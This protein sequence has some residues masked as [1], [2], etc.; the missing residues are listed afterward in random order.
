[1]L[2]HYRKNNQHFCYDSKNPPTTSGLTTEP[3]PHGP[4]ADKENG[5]EELKAT[6]QMAW[7]QQMNNIRNRA[8]EIVNAEL[9]YTI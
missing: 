8:T 7:V 4:F 3:R 1:M 5:P 9:I 2:I 6:D